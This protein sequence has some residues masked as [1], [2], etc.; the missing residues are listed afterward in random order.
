[1]L[2]QRL[3]AVHAA[4]MPGVFAEVRDGPRTWTPA[5]GV[6]DVRTGEPVRDGLRHRVGSITKTFVAATVLQLAGEGRIR[7]DAPIGRY[8]P[9]GLV[10]TTSS[11]A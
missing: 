8:L 11:P 9:R 1:V 6:I 5:A 3:E 10:P 2:R 4:G 7:L